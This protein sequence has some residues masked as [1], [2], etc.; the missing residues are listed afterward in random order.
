MGRL[1]GSIMCDVMIL[2]WPV[3][4]GCGCAQLI[5]ALAKMKAKIGKM[6]FAIC[7]FGKENVEGQLWSVPCGK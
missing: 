6:R 4:I 1:N 5:E 7:C 3:E 2:P